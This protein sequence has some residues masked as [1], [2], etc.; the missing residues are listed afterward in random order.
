MP[1]K[2]VRLY[3]KGQ[4]NDFRDA[5]AIAEAVQRP[6]MKFVAT[7][8]ARSS[9]TCSPSHRVRERLVRQRT[10]IINQIR[11]PFL[12]ES[13][14]AVRQ[15]QRFL[16]SALPGILGAPPDVLSPRMVR[17]IEDLAAD[18]RRAR[19]WPPNPLEQTRQAL[20]LVTPKPFVPSHRADPVAPAQLANVHPYGLFRARS[21]F[22]C[23]DQCCPRAR[24]LRCCSQRLGCS[25]VQLRFSLASS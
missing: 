1:A 7:K 19:L 14:I 20:L 15:G 8:T 23:I 21:L 13:G 3:S 25:A 2:Y 4:K 24:P 18:W 12:L 6:I 9:S 22:P 11:A 5:G 16:R 10:G 17:L